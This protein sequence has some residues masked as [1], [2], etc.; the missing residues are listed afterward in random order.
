[1]AF[2][3]QVILKSREAG[4][5]IIERAMLTLEVRA[6]IALEA[7]LDMLYGPLFFR[8]LAGHQPLSPE[9]AEQLVETL[10]DG[11]KGAAR[12]APQAPPTRP[13]RPAARG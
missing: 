11:V 3:N 9:L 7:V 10:F 12:S 13:K 1:K 6:D 5:R 4:R 8:L 2:R